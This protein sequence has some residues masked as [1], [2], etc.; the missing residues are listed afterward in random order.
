[1]VQIWGATKDMTAEKAREILLED[2]RSLK[3]NFGASAL[4]T[5]GY[6]HGDTGAGKLSALRKNR[7]QGSLM[8]EK[9]SGPHP[10]LI[11][12]GRERTAPD[13]PEKGLISGQKIVMLGSKRANI[14]KVGFG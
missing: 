9:V 14:R 10:R 2:E 13:T 8:L 5:R 4:V 12:V 3:A 7:A 1:M 6:G 11:Q